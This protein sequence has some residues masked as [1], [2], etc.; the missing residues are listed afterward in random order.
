MRQRRVERRELHRNGDSDRFLQHGDNVDH[1]ALDRH[2]IFE[3][4]RGDVIEVQLQGIGAGLLDQ[5]GVVQPP[6]RFGAVQR[7]DHRHADAPFDPQQQLEIVVRLGAAGD[8]LFLEQGVHDD[9]R[10]AGILEP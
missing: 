8:D 2:G 7:G 1:A 3:K 10:R 9:G 4:V 6:F 5:P